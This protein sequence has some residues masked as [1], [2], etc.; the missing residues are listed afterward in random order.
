MVQELRGNIRVFVRVKPSEPAGRSGAPVLACEDSHRISCTAAGSTKAFEFDRVFGPESSQEQ[1]FGEV[2]QLITS[3][4]DGYNVCIFAYGQTGAGKTYTMEGTRQDPGINYRTMKEL[5]RCIKEDREGGTTYD[6][7]TSIVELYNEQVWDLLAESGKKEVELV[8]ATSGAGFN[9]PD[10]TQ[11]AVTS[12]EQILDIM[13]R[14]FEQRATGC[15]D[16]N[17][18]S[19]RSHCLLIVHAATTDPATGVRSV[20]KLTLCDLAGSERINKT[21]ASGLTLTEAQNINRSLL[22]LGNVISA[23]MQQSSHVPYRNSKLTML[24]QDSLGGNAKALMVANLAPSP[25]HASETLSSL[26]FASK[27]ANVVLKTPQRKFEDVPTAGEGPPAVGK[28]GG[29][30][31]LAARSGALRSNL[32]AD[33]PRLRAAQP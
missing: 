27:V 1:I 29:T 16:I 25:A 21:G 13:A 20:G 32:S 17:A 2:S 22:E 30:Q 12:P 18:H 28:A 10:L 24:L 8:K 33:R 15:H 7:T 6:I 11:V 26:A 5:F 4:L 19:S 3:A 9:V 23:L 31:S 14:G